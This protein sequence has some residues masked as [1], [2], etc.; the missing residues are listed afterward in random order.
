[1]AELN[2]ST[3]RGGAHQIHPCGRGRGHIDHQWLITGSGGPHSEGVGAK[4]GYL[5]TVGR[6][7]FGAI[8]EHQRH[9]TLTGEASHKPTEHARG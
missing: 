6:Y 5:A 3:F 2:L 9:Q 4:K 1:M 8:G 7:G